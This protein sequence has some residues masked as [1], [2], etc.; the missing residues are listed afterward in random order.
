[1]RTTHLNIKKYFQLSLGL[2]LA[3]SIGS[4]LSAFGNNP[5]PVQNSSGQTTGEKN[6]PQCKAIAT[7]QNKEQQ[8]VTTKTDKEPNPTETGKTGK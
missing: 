6:C 4:S 7:E 8:S 3:S 5:E 1:M 2:L